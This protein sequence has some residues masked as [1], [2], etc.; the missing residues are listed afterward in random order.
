MDVALVRWPAEAAKRVSLLAEGKPVLLL[1]E[2]GAPPQNVS[3]LEDWIR[4]PSREADMRSRMDALE[5]R[6]QSFATSIAQFGSDGVPQ[7]DDGGILRHGPKWVSLSPLEVRLVRALLER[8]GAVVPRQKL[9]EVLWP[10]DDDSTVGPSRSAL[11]SHVL[12]LRRR[13]TPIGL[14]IR[15]VRARG[16]LLRRVET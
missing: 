5:L 14:T 11:D 10:P 6:V 3:P 16:Y 9:I 8:P 1:V 15:T 12:R 2:S 13:L 4:V 7:V